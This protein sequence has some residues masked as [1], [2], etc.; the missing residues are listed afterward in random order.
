MLLLNFFAPK[1]APRII[2]PSAISAFILSCAI[3]IDLFAPPVPKFI[4]SS[5]LNIFIFAVKPKRL[6]A[7]I[8]LSLVFAVAFLSNAVLGFLAAG[9]L[10]AGFL[11]SCF[12]AACFSFAFLRAAVCCFLSASCSLLYS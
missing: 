1:F 4:V 10:A 3:L 6:A 9:F 7:C 11:A 5:R 12:L 2:L 8:I